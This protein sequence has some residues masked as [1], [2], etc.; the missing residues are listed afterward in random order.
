MSW[1]SN[2]HFSCCYILYRTCT[3][4][5]VNVFIVSRRQRVYNLYQFNYSAVQINIH[6][7]AVD[8]TSAYTTLTWWLWP[9]TMFPRRVMLAQLS[10]IVNPVCSEISNSVAGSEYPYHVTSYSLY[11]NSNIERIVTCVPSSMWPSVCTATPMRQARIL[12][13]SNV[14]WSS[15][16]DTKITERIALWMDVQD[17]TDAS[18]SFKSIS[19]TSLGIW[20]NMIIY[21][22]VVLSALWQG[23]SSIPLKIYD[24]CN[25]SSIARSSSISPAMTSSS[26]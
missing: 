22:S 19:D 15:V 23:W 14:S 1:S 10:N 20:V 8:S 2:K 6:N 26:S 24:D 16:D 25:T 3:L 5:F 11:I 13:Y 9:N 17:R 12:T 18:V 4:L 21:A 7:A